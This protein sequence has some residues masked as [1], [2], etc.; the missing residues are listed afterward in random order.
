MLIQK[1]AMCDKI[2]I[3]V[4]GVMASFFA[5][6]LS[7][8]HYFVLLYIYTEQDCVVDLDLALLLKSWC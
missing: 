3:G 1:E 2:G 8:L 4:Y 6:K 7:L 5:H